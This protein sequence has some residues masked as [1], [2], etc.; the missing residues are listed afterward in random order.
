MKTIVL[1]VQSLEQMRV[2]VRASL[3]QP[4]KHA[5]QAEY[6]RMLS[7]IS[8][9]AAVAR[10]RLAEGTRG[11]QYKLNAIILL[12]WILHLML[13]VAI[14]LAIC[15]SWLAL[16]S[17]PAL[18]ALLL[19]LNHVQTLLN[20]EIAARLFVLDEMLDNKPEILDNLELPKE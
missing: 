17:L 10:G 5:A 13:P 15:W 1:P 12:R 14:V 20:V 6:A 7:I 18:V 9:P 8:H 2:Q 19:G 4:D 11:L 3:N 16:L